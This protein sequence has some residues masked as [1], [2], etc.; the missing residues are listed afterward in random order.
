MTYYV[1]AATSVCLACLG[2]VLYRRR[3]TRLQR[4]PAYYWVAP[5][6]VRML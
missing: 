3:K 1:L 5:S 4:K 2:V 6:L